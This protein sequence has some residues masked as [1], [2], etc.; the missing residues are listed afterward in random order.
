MGQSIFWHTISYKRN[1]LLNEMWQMVFIAQ[2]R[3]FIKESKEIVQ[4]EATLAND[5]FH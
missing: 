4:N 2:K 1:R 5:S 3:M